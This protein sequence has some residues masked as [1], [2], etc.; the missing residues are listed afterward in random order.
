M[1]K[2]V[3]E[4]GGHYNEDCYYDTYSLWGKNNV[5]YWVIKS[6][7]LYEC[8]RC[9]NCL[10]VLICRNVRTAATVIVAI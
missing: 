3:Y 6:E 4:R 7:C 10:T 5:G 8:I 2:I 9:E 1:T